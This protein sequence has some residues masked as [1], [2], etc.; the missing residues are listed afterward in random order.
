MNT[1]LLNIESNVKGMGMFVVAFD[2]S[3]NIEIPG[4]R[5]LHHF[6]EHL[7]CKGWF[8]YLD[9]IKSAGIEF[10]ALTYNDKVYY[11]W[12]GLDREITNE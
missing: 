2:G 7:T 3:A 12:K 8:P 9:E 5:G 4:Q 1:G 10:N 11:Y 6:A